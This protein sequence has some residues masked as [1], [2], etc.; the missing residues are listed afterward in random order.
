M[1]Q[2]LTC[3]VL[4]VKCTSH[5]KEGYQCPDGHQRLDLRRLIS[6]RKTPSEVDQIGEVATPPLPLPP[7]PLLPSRDTKGL[8]GGRPFVDSWSATAALSN[9]V[10]RV[11]GVLGGQHGEDTITDLTILRQHLL[12]RP[13]NSG[14]LPRH[15]HQHGS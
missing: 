4:F 5:V 12:D 10:R 13:H 1:Y 2:Y 11:E 15:V 8:P 6:G 3:E 7:A 14:H 9:G